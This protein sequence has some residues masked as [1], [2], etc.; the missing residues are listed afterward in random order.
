MAERRNYTD[1]YW[2]SRD[3]LRLHYRD[4]A[5][6]ADKPPILC[7]PGLTRNARDFEMLAD[8]LAGAWRVLCLDFR[9]RGESAYAKDPMSYVP[10]TYLQDVE[11]LVH[12][13]AIERFVSVGTSLGGIVTMLLAATDRARL[14]GVVLNDVGPELNPSGLARIR[15]YVGKA[16]W[17]PTWM[18]AARHVAEAHGDVYPG[19]GVEEWLCMAKRLYRVNSSGRIVLDYDM[20][21]AEP[22]RV[23]GN[24]AGPD[25]WPT[26]DAMRGRPVLVVR[27][28]RSDIL[29]APAAEKMAARLDDAELVTVPGVG[30]APALDEPE[31]IAAM[32]RT[33]ARVR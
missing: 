7:L 21:I 16:V 33:L 8:R 6:P 13:L 26:L 20:K 18:H 28:E 5:G 9:G 12:E 10:L 2:W 24:E 22:F 4:Y 17:H 1:A 27:G 25:L 14:A 30:H 31:V 23:P 32:E 29:S 11:A 19:Y 15:T 3:G